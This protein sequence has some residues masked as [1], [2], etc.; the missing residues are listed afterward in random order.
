M[1]IHTIVTSQGTF[2]SDTYVLR[3][4]KSTTQLNWSEIRWGVSPSGDVKSPASKLRPTRP[5]NIWKGK[6]S[7]YATM[8][9]YIFMQTFGPV[10]PNTQICKLAFHSYQAHHTGINLMTVLVEFSHTLTKH[11]IKINSISEI[12]KIIPD[13]S[14]PSC[15]GDKMTRRTCQFGSNF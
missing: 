12:S 14:S 1:T 11:F 15:C 7:K 9:H 3:V 6:V 5:P 8:Q 4:A 2:L 10:P 13:L